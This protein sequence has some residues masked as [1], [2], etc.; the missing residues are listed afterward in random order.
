MNGRMPQ[1]II[2][3]DPLNIKMPCDLEVIWKLSL[4]IFSM[5]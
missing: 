2:K 1:Y 4:N 3:K 5:A